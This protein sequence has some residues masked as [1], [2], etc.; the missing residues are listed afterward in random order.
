MSLPGLFSF[1]IS[2]NLSLQESVSGSN[3]ECSVHRALA[4][5]S[6]QPAE[7]KL[8]NALRIWATQGCIYKNGHG[9][10]HHSAIL[11]YSKQAMCWQRSNKGQK[12][13]LF[14]C[15][16]HWLCIKQQ[17]L[18]SLLDLN[19]FSLSMSVRAPPQHCIY[20]LLCGSGPAAWILWKHCLLLGHKSSSS[21]GQSESNFS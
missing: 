14:T 21:L 12:C 3:L 4:E 10:W 11:Y 7:E 19:F 17:I 9:D 5:W 2:C 6:S 18:W 8:G 20:K 16:K 15:V 13:P 1:C